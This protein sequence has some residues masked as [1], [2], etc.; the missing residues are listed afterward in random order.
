MHGRARAEES[1]R[2]ATGGYRCVPHPPL[3]RLPM[4]FESTDRRMRIYDTVWDAR[5]VPRD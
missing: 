5:A 3:L 4:S 2:T 1:H